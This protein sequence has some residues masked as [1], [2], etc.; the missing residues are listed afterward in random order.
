MFDIKVGFPDDVDSFVRYTILNTFYL[1]NVLDEHEQFK[2]FY[3]SWKSC[4]SSSVLDAYIAELQDLIDCNVTDVE[5]PSTTPLVKFSAMMPNNIKIPRYK[6]IATPFD[7]Y[8][9]LF[10]IFAN[11]FFGVSSAFIIRF[12][13]KFYNLQGYPL[14]KNLFFG[15]FTF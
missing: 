3:K 14:T 9:G 5:I 11:I 7:L 15:T 12:R 6:Y 10:T 4:E 8:V 1:L 2:V 13:R